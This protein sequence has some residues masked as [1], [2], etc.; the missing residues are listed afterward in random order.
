MKPNAGSASPSLL[1]TP[2]S[3]GW[4]CVTTALPTNSTAVAAS[5]GS[6]KKQDSSASS[7]ANEYT[8][9]YP[10][11]WTTHNVRC[12]WHSCALE[13]RAVHDTLTGFV[14]HPRLPSQSGRDGDDQCDLC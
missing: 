7:A 2:P 5:C 11:L 10:V 4:R 14:P 3:G 12:V 6:F 1:L 13:V 9:R 8:E